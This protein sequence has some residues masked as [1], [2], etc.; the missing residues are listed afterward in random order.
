MPLWKGKMMRSL[1]EG[2]GGRGWGVGV[3]GHE[4]RKILH[5]SPS[6]GKPLW[7]KGRMMVSLQEGGGG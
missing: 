3:S 2:E 6:D 4:G 5:D 1:Q 7:K